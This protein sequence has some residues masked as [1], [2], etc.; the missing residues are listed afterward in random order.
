MKPIVKKTLFA[1]VLMLLLA[2]A[3]FASNKGTPQKEVPLGKT[4]V[5][6]E[7]AFAVNRAR[8]AVLIM[9]Y[10]ND[11]VGSLPEEVRVPL[12]EH[13]A[14]IVKEARL[15]KIPVI[16]VAVRFRDGY[17]E[18]DLRNKLFHALKESGRLR[19]GT[20]GAEI[21]PRVAP[22]LNEVVVTKRRVGAFSNTD[23]ETVLRAGNITTLVLCGITTSGVV[24]STVRWAAD[25]DYALVVVSDACADR[26][27]EVQRVLMDKIFPWQATI[28]TSSE[29]LTAII[30]AANK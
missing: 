26:D 14:A 18:I 29:L 28:V 25:K 2:G 17:P 12:L 3:V 30:A 23:L 4:A 24:L 21:D 6:I 9:D 7:P 19:E 16:Y 11:I 13:A 10:Q 27:P 15:A 5:L 8:T 1:A 22:L 20:P